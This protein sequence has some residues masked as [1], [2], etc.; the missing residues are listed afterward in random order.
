LN[1]VLS[2]DNDKTLYAS[3]AMFQVQNHNNSWYQSFKAQAL[4]VYSD[5]AVM[6]SSSQSSSVTLCTWRFGCMQCTPTVD[7]Q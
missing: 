1:T 6:H 4:E 5:D 7:K 2:N 3:F